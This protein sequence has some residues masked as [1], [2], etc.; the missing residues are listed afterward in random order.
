MKGTPFYTGEYANTIGKPFA[1]E[2]PPGTSA[3]LPLWYY[4]VDSYDYDFHIFPPV[5]NIE[6]RENGRSHWHF[7]PHARQSRD[8]RYDEY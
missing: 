2:N 3:I 7:F 1:S 6:R 8:P 5:F 4:E